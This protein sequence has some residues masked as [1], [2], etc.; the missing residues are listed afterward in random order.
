[1]KCWLLNLAVFLFVF[2]AVQIALWAYLPRT[3]CNYSEWNDTSCN[4]AGQLVGWLYWAL[5]L[6]LGWVASGSVEKWYMARADK[7]E[8]KTD[9][10]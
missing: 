5:A 2:F 6:T 7:K 3:G 9:A 1:M 8:S 10:D 4:A